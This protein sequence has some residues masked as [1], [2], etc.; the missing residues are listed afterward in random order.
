MTA[1]WRRKRESIL[2]RDGYLCQAARRYGQMIPAT[3][4]H[5]IFPL[6]EFPEY[7]FEDWNLVSLSASAHNELH[8]RSTDA[9]TPKGQ[10]LLRRTA[11]KNGIPIPAKY[12][13]GER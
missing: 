5:H 3:T 8:D 11:R 12:R 13:G 10:D 9:L 7:S 4:V 6:E 2:K 1:R